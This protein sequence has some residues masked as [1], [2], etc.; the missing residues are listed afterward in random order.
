VE[1]SGRATG[2]KIKIQ[3]GWTWSWSAASGKSTHDATDGGRER[4]HASRTA[5]V[6]RADRFGLMMYEQLAATLEEAAEL[7]RSV[8]TPVCADESAESLER[9]RRSSKSRRPGY[10]HQ[11]PARAGARSSPHDDRQAGLECW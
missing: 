6:S 11:D 10:Q 8:R 1:V 3:P 2:V 4:R 5:G 7:S 9:W